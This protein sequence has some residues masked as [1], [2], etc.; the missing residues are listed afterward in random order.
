MATT[1]VLFPWK[2][3]YSVHIPRIDTQHR[4]LVALI[5]DLHAAMLEGRAK[6]AMAGIVDELVD[7]TVQ[8]FAFEESML[9]QHGYSGLAEHQQIHEKL[10]SQ[11]FELRD[12][13][14]AGKISVTIET[15][16][17]LKN[18]LSDHILSEDMAYAR[19]LKP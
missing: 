11:V 2:D 8:H 10:R 14:R 16:H 15:M 9:R 13:F 19:E 5:N 4:G 6:E 12:K 1:T 18:W 3:S 17:F 7:Y